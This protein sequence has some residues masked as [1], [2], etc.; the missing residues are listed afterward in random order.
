MSQN[1]FFNILT[2]DWPK[3]PV[4][5]YF[6]DKD[7]GFGTKLHSTLFP[8]EIRKIFP[9]LSSDFDTYIYTTFNKES[10]G[11]KS[12]SIDF[13]SDNPDL[14][15]RYYNGEIYHY[16]AKVLGKRVRKNFIKESQVWH[17]SK[18][19]STE[20][21]GVFDKFSLKVQLAQVSEFPELVI[22]YD[23]QSR[24]LKHSVNSLLSKVKPNA[25][26]WLMYQGRFIKWEDTPKIEGFN[27]LNAYPILN[28]ELEFQLDLDIDYKKPK[29]RYK[30]YLDGISYFT[31]N[32]LLT[33]K[34]RKIIPINTKHFLSVH[35]NEVGECPPKSNYLLFGQKQLAA[36]TKIA[37]NTLYPYK[38]STYSNI[39]VFYIYHEHDIE[40]REKIEKQL[41]EGMGHFKGLKSYVN[42][43]FYTDVEND[44]VFS[45]RE[46]PFNQIKE[47]VDKR[48]WD[49]A[50]KYMAVYITPI[51]KSVKERSK[52]K[53]YYQLKE[54]LLYKNI[55][56]QVIDPE[57]MIAA[58]DNW[59]YSLPNIA[60]AMLAKLEGIPW[61]LANVPK[62]EL[63]VGIGAYTHK[64]E[65]VQYIGSAFS[66]SSTGK[67]NNFD[68]FLKSH[69]SLLAG[70][71]ADK[72]SE[73]AL[74]NGNPERIV[75]HF[76]KEMSKK[77][78]DVI[79]SE[80]EKLGKK[81]VVIIV[82]VNKTESEDIV[83]FSNDNPDLMPPGGT[84]VS[85]GENRY[86]L[87]NNNYVVGERYSLFDGFPFPIKLKIQC[88]DP[89]KIE[90]IT[91]KNELIR[92]VYQFSRLYYKS[93]SQQ[94]LPVTVKYPEMVAE[95]APFF[96]D[97]KIP[98]FGKDKLWFL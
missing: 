21:W 28:N 69:I 9:A 85:I 48:D 59:K 12:L 74:H 78:R 46:E 19:F 64:E 63:V 67:F 11:F 44:I 14:V 7:P 62:T 79:I 43:D 84:F 42:L 50:V 34:F 25:F 15:K 22:S 88:T 98:P 39:H 18:F 3:E 40:Y 94:N 17:Y 52:K 58:G 35:P 27:S 68:Y 33:E 61:T 66:F 97:G 76:Y 75:I 8:K 55:V 6:T 56:S 23:K 83:A 29:N 24:I 77:E 16:F 73:Y 38:N 37:L 13:R 90:S 89:A 2:F 92:Q 71:I 65:G 91:E 31:N 72:V 87:F 45:S 82:T 96:V 20:D 49:P 26:N 95:M 53:I 1:L 41:R 93:V 80:L 36:D 54:L 47:I 32:Y 5:F 30:D 60:I 4:K 81:Y 10:A 70:S 86:L 57:K 51:S